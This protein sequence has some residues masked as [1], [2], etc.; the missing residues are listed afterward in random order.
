METFVLAVYGCVGGV[1]VCVLI[2]NIKCV[3]YWG[4][5]QKVKDVSQVHRVC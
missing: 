5:G 2:C 3:C 4:C 1:R